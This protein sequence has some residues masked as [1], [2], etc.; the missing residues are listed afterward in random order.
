MNK[1]IENKIISVGY[2]KLQI[3]HHHESDYKDIVD[4]H[5]NIQKHSRFEASVYACLD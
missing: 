2:V 1:D 3:R 4:N 5:S